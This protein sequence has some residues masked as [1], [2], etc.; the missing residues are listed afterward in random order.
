MVS[1]KLIEIKA[2]EK[3]LSVTWQVSNFCNFSCTYC[4]PGNWIGDSP[5]EGNLDKYI[6]NIDKIINRYKERDYKHF[7]FFF[8]GGEPTAWKNFIPICKHLKEIMPE[9]TIAINTNLSRPEA[10]WKKHLYL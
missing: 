6:S 8:S 1:K 2:P 9:C 3:Y 7:K 10:W 4:N 5:N